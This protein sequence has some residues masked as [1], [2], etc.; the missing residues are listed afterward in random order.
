REHAETCVGKEG[1]AGKREHYERGACHDPRPPDPDPVRRRDQ[2]E[3]DQAEAHIAPQP[4]GLPA[5]IKLLKG[6][7]DSVE[8]ECPPPRLLGPAPG[9]HVVKSPAKVE[10]KR[11]DRD[12]G[13]ECSPERSSSCW[14]ARGMT[15][16]D[17]NRRERQREEHGLRPS[18]RRCG[19]GH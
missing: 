13:G 5:C 15:A 9:R 14:T 16:A 3:V 10:R 7:Y 12:E 18:Q 1:P 6:T 17:C 4:G 2:P 11:G 19:A 8:R